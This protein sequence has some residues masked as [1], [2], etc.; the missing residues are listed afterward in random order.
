MNGTHAVSNPA[1][2]D[3]RSL[4]PI[5]STLRRED[6]AFERA[7]Q[8]HHYAAGSVV[9]T[10]DDLVHMMYVLMKGRVNLVCTS[11]TG[12]Q[13]VVA[14]LEPGAIFGQGALYETGDSS[15][16]V[17][18][19]D[20]IVVWT[21]PATEARNVTMQYPILSWGLLQ[22]YGERLHQV[23]ENLENIVCKKL[24]ERLANLLLELGNY[25]NGL[26][27]G[28][29][30]QTLADYLGTYRETVSAA[31]RDFKRRKL[32]KIGYRRIE[33]LQVERLKDIAGVWE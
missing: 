7:T 29:C 15:V 12:R 26:I 27:E 9:A 28:Y 6:A 8:I 23:Q 22:T 5:L 32:I 16:F 3:Y 4:A 25:Q 18:A 14:M 13:L 31:L 10:A 24:P 1:L 2:H 11:P 21:I 30:H 20:D 33:I 17:K 19:A